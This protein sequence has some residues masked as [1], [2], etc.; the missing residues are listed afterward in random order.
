MRGHSPNKCGGIGYY[1]VKGPDI[2]VANPEIIIFI[3]ISSLAVVS[4]YSPPIERKTLMRPYLP[5]SWP[6][7]QQQ[8]SVVS[9]PNP[10]EYY[11]ETYGDFECN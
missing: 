7:I 2:W 6:G 8:K 10:S 11:L 1:E 5:C 3:L 9:F 4:Q